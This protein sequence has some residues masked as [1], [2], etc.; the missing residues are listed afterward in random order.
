MIFI[1]KINIYHLKI[2]YYIKTVV[3]IYLNVYFTLMAKLFICYINTLFPS[4][5]KKLLKYVIYVILSITKLLL[6]FSPHD[7]IITSDAVVVECI[8][9]WTLK[10]NSAIEIIPE[11]RINRFDLLVVIRVF[12]IN[13]RL[14]VLKSN[15]IF[16]DKTLM[17]KCTFR[18]DKWLKCTTFKLL[19]T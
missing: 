18:I 8:F 19:C 4:E 9:C 13:K 5:K 15:S 7:Y 14:W 17:K 16:S 6:Y 3:K 11:E 12:W 1:D 2:K 10:H